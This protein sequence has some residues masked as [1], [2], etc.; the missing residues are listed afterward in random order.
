MAQLTGERGGCCSPTRAV[1]WSNIDDVEIGKDRHGLRTGRRLPLPAD[2]GD[3]SAGGIAAWALMRL[4]ATRRGVFGDGA[5]SAFNE[6]HW[7][8]GVLLDSKPLGSD[9][10]ASVI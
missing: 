3:L 1:E 6:T 4:G 7:L 2:N 9:D 8:G 10:L 5:T